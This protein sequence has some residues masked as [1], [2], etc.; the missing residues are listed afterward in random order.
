M[1]VHI[2]VKPGIAHDLCVPLADA[3]EQAIR[4]MNTERS[5]CFVH[6]D[7][8]TDS[9]AADQKQADRRVAVVIQTSARYSDSAKRK[10]FGLIMDRLERE[11]AIARI[12][13]LIGLVETPA[14]NWTSG[15]QER[16]WLQMMA[17]QLP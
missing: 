14:A 3:V 16:Q 4:Q 2:V 15:S 17:Y 10:L 11:F 1:F 13:V 9:P 8:Q 6:V 5:R 7:R 12:D